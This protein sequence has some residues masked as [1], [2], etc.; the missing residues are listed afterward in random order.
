M[1][2]NRIGASLTRTQKSAITVAFAT[3]H[4]ERPRFLCKKQ[5]LN[6]S[7]SEENDS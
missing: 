6:K 3:L 7:N 5:A 2:V 4:D 1:P